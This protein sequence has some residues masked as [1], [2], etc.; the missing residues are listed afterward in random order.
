MIIKIEKLQVLFSEY[1]FEVL[2]SLPIINNE[3]VQVLYYF[4]KSNSSMFIDTS[5]IVAQALG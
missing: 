5:L 1:T 4:V 2:F 3:I